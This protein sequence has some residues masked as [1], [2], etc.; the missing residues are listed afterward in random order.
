MGASSLV[1]W[2]RESWAVFALAV[3]VLLPA[4]PADDLGQLW[5]EHEGR[6][7]PFAEF[8]QEFVRDVSGTGRLGGQDPV[9]TVLS[10]LADPG[11]WEAV[12]CIKVPR[13]ARPQLGLPRDAGLVSRRQLEAQ[14]RLDGVL[15]AVRGRLAR[16]RRLT[17]LERGLATVDRRRQALETVINQELRL[18][19]PADAADGWQPILRPEGYP[20]AQ[21]MAVKR[22]WAQLLE[23]FREGRQDDCRAVAGRLRRMLENLREEQRPSAIVLTRHPL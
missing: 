22:T 17:P 4:H 16:G 2:L 5:I 1:G 12:A 10:M 7:K 21:Q 14:P 6:V 11:R 18:V 8:A 9:V 3:G 19:P 15:A 13:R 20:F 23:A